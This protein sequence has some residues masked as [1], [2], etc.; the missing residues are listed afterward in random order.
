MGIG[1]TIKN[2]DDALAKCPK[3]Y[4]LSRNEW[5]DLRVY[6]QERSKLQSD[7]KV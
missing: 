4:Y 2:A 3:L 7:H 1:K 6:T 5:V